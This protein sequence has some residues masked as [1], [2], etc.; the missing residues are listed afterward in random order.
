MGATARW[1]KA[2]LHAHCSLDPDDWRICDYSPEQLVTEAARLGYEILAITCHNLDVWNREL[3]EF[4]EGLGITLIP[5]MEVTVEGSYHLLAYN[6][7]IGCEGLNSF[8]K[9]RRAARADTMVVAPHPFYPGT[10]CL[11]GLVDRNIDI[12]DA[13]EV[14]GFHTSHLDF[15]GRARKVAERRGK[16]LAGNGDVHFLWQL[17]RTYS[18]IYCEPGV[19][20]ALR[21]VKEGRVRVQSAPL[22]LQQAASWWAVTAWRYAFPA[23]SRPVHPLPAASAAA[24]QGEELRITE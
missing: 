12:F 10:S 19:V 23:N 14:S 5:G 7:G 8:E 16:P 2:E 3:S 18:W 4:A 15:N 13:I 17:D 9:I 21:A 11:G 22:S 6:F 20:P 24:H 1:R